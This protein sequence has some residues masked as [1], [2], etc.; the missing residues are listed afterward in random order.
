M[1]ISSFRLA[2]A[3]ITVPQKPKAELTSLEALDSL[4]M[5]VSYVLYGEFV[6]LGG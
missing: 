4:T 5:R 1:V 6:S 3:R 2:S